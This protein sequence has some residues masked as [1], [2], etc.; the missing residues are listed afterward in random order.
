MLTEGL[1]LEAPVLQPG[2]GRCATHW[3]EPQLLSRTRFGCNL[4]FTPDDARLTEAARIVSLSHKLECRVFYYLKKQSRD[5][6]RGGV[7]QFTGKSHFTLRGM[8]S[9]TP[10]EEKSGQSHLQALDKQD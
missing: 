4:G 10:T 1:V 8:L 2:P 5:S 6:R 3:R 7:L 9:A